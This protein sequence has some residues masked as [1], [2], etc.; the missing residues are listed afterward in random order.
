MSAYR[1][2]TRK[3]FVVKDDEALAKITGIPA[4]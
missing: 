1:F 4:V 2:V 3:G